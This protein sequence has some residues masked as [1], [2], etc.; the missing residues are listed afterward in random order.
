MWDEK[1]YVEKR[2]QVMTGAEIAYSALLGFFPEAAGLHLAESFA[3]F[4]HLIK[5][6]GK[7]QY[8]LKKFTMP[9]DS[10]CLFLSQGRG[11]AAELL[12]VSLSVK[13][14][15]NWS[16]IPGFLCR[17]VESINSSGLGLCLLHGP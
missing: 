12:D 2:E 8:E 17:L 1:S 3:L 10:S 7:V 11:I 9:R 16:F 14:M 13:Y 15:C 5:A 6:K 4:L